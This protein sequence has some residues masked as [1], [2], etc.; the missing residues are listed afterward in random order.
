MDEQAKITPQKLFSKK[1][2]KTWKLF[3]IFSGDK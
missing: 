1:F 3:G 2:L